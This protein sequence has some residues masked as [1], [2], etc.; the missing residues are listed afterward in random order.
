MSLA[1]GPCF[2]HR[3]TSY[4]PQLGPQSC[5]C[6]HLLSTLAAT[7]SSHTSGLGFPPPENG[8]APPDLGPRVGPPTCSS[9]PQEVG[10]KA[11]ARCKDLYVR[12]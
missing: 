2:G 1:P 9:E 8:A 3:L 11:T 12:T 4:L 5:I 6:L 7:Y 10:R